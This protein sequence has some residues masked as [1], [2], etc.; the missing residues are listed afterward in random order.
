Q[1]GAPTES[2]MKKKKQIYEDSLNSTRAALEEGIVP[3]GGIALLQAAR[4]ISLSLSSEEQIGAQILIKACEAPF[5]QIIT[6]TGYDAAIILE[7]V[8]AKNNKTYG[9][10]AL[11]E[12]IED[13]LAAGI[14]DPV[15]VIK[16]SLRHAVSMA[17]VVLLS[18]ALIANE[19]DT[20]A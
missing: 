4:S 12:T 3:G 2:E 10:N 5:R 17:G 6:N 9:F 1:V 15:K 19:E 18:E 14:I 20:S 7:Q 8:L 16:S 13:L 11:T